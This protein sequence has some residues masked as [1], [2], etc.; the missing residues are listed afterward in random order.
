MREISYHVP[1]RPPVSPPAPRVLLLSAYDAASH[2]HWRE[3]L[4]AMFPAMD[5]TVLALPARYFAWRV[6]GNSL[7][8]A[9]N[10]RPILSDNYD[11]LIATSM[12]DLSALRGFVPA[13]ASIPTL[14][15]FHENQFA[16]PRS[17]RQISSAELQILSLYTALCADA[18]VFNSAWNRSS[19]LGGAAALLRKLPDH[20]PADLE[21]RLAD[22]LVLPVPLPDSLYPDSAT[23]PMQDDPAAPLEIVWNH[24][25]E[26]DKG[27]ELLLAIVR[28]LIRRQVRFRLHL[29]GEEFRQAPQQFAQLRVE[30][31]SYC[32]RQNIAPASDGWLEK[33]DDYLRLLHNADVALSTALHD[34]Q[35]IALLEAAACGCSPLAPAALVYPEYLDADFLY[36]FSDAA[37]DTDWT[38]SANAAVDRLQHLAHL[39]SSGNVL[40]QADVSRFRNSSLR[41]GYDAVISRLLTT[42]PWTEP[43]KILSAEQ[44][45][46]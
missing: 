17:D 9:F 34:F 22:S 29:L 10:H 15:Y 24:R 6:R 12:V 30:L 1:G 33:R 26:Y 36:S 5:W 32:A 23:A 44:K 42:R 8:W 38:T 41:G 7:S 37:I 16:Y 31:Q 25:R 21:T 39:K 43:G 13:L 19:F 45:H 2:R 18:L 4:V 28:E 14:V 27:P 20:V 35:G 40:P 3:N 46:G 11:L